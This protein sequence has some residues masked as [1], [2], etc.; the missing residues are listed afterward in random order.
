[1]PFGQERTVAVR[2]GDW[3]AIRPKP[4]AN[5]ELYNLRD[6]LAETTDLADGNPGVLAKIN[7]TLASQHAPQRVYPPEKPEPTSRDYVR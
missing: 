7:R 3:K 4:D 5:L 6:D 1:M 2:M